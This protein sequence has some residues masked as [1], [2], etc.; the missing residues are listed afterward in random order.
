MEAL[1]NV[2]LD[3]LILTIDHFAVRAL[4]LFVLTP[5][6][7]LILI[8]TMLIIIRLKTALPIFW[9]CGQALPYP[10]FLP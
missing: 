10:H 3:L 5:D 6:C 7:G 8:P 2:T 1:L 9:S 4:L